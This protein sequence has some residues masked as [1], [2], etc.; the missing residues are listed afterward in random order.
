MRHL[1]ECWP[2]VARRLKNASSLALF[3]DFDGTLAR[4][5]SRPWLAGLS[6]ETRRNL[7]RLAKHRSVQVCVISGRDRGKLRKLIGV[8]S[9]RCL[10][11]YGW[12]NGRNKALD[13]LTRAALA[14]ARTTLAS[15][16]CNVPGVWL[17]NKSMAFAVHYRGAPADSVRRARRTLRSVVAPC[18]QLR[19]IPAKKAW[20][21]VPASLTGKGEAVRRELCA[22]PKSLAIYAGDDYADEKAFTAIRGGI[23]IHVG[24]RRSS[25]AQFRLRNPDE[26]RLFLEKLEEV[27]K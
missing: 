24:A 12:Q 17:E 26:V 2:D 4:I 6:A 22:L 8:P 14:T 23:A 7:A 25:N 11:L 19:I 15:R 5:V 10:G 20:E 9:V 21:V 18:R 13:A 27:L 1:F 16:L 3:L